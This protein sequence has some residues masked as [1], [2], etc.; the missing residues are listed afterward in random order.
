MPLWL[1]G[2]RDHGFR[3]AYARDDRRCKKV[4]NRASG[5]TE[6]RSRKNDRYELGE[7]KKSWIVMGGCLSDFY[8]ASM[9]DF[10]SLRSAHCIKNGIDEDEK[11]TTTEDLDDLYSKIKPEDLI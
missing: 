6:E 7:F 1:A 4:G 3:H 5:G 8:G 9:W 2:M 10:Q 11:E